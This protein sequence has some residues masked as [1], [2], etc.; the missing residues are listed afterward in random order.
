MSIPSCQ[1]SHDSSMLTIT[2]TLTSCQCSL[3]CLF[4]NLQSRRW[5]VGQ[6]P[7]DLLHNCHSSHRRSE[8]ELSSRAFRF[9]LYTLLVVL[10]TRVYAFFGRT[11]KMLLLLSA[12]FIMVLGGM[13][14]IAGKIISQE[15]CDYLFSWLY[16]PPDS[17]RL[18][19]VFITID[20]NTSYGHQC[21][22]SNVPKDF[23][24]VFLIPIL[25]GDSLLLLLVMGR[26][27]QNF[28]AYGRSMVV[29]Q[30]TMLILKDS[31]LCFC[32]CVFTVYQCLSW[33]LFPFLPE[34]QALTS[35]INFFGS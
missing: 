14:G 16:L 34:Q 6:I 23:A 29:S 24:N 10:L 3:V 28:Y 35:L 27:I 2:L 11:P 15:I 30:L 32:A 21:L 33:R 17:F 7:L 19:V 9:C 4:D 26:A 20:A 22:I 5:R 25:T 31:V 12:I 13:A 1:C 8:Y 18:S